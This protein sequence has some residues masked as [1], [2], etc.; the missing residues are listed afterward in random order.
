MK[1]STFPT[2]EVLILTCGEI[3]VSGLTVLGYFL[4]SLVF[5]SVSFSYRPITG[6]LLGTLVTVF[7]FL[8]L[9]IS[10]NACVDRVLEAR[11]TVEMDEEEAEKFAAEHSAQ[12]QN[13]IKASFIVR[14]LS[15]IATLVVAFLLDWFAPIATVIPMLCYK[16]ILMFG[17]VIRRKFDTGVQQQTLLTEDGHGADTADADRREDAAELQRQLCELKRRI[18]EL[19]GAPDAESDN[20]EDEEDKG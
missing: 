13:R 3:I 18:A 5:D 10:V 4:A 11:G 2:R 8:F 1:N 12:I 16:P 7:N 14:S 15:M 17:E 19:E 9:A 6:A 20:N